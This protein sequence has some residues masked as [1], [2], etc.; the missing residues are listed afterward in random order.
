M[1]AIR[2]HCDGSSY[3]ALGNLYAA[4]G[5]RAPVAVRRAVKRKGERARSLMIRAVRDVLQIT[6]RSVRKRI[7]GRMISSNSY[8]IVARGKIPLSEFATTQESSGVKVTGIPTDWI[9]GAANLGI[10]FQAKK[11]SPKNQPGNAVKR[12]GSLGGRIVFGTGKRRRQGFRS[13][14]GVMVPAAFIDDRAQRAFEKVAHELPQ[15]I[16]HQ[17]WVVGQGLDLKANRARAAR[18]ALGRTGSDDHGG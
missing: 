2:L 8:E 15:E 17:L 9:E 11:G 3:R 16:A 1:T 7:K 14:G 18:L 12:R 5:Q 13:V 6:L 4:A 10:A